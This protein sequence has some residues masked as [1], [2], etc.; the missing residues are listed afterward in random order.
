MDKNSFSSE[1]NN[2]NYNNPI[3]LHLYMYTCHKLLNKFIRKR[4]NEQEQASREKEAA[5]NSTYL[6]PN[7]PKKK[8]TMSILEKLN[9][10]VHAQSQNLL[11]SEKMV[12][13]ARA[14]T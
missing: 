13:E 2:H 5:Q 11:Q 9:I 3:L 1:E 12:Y 4:F 8:V 6:L 14:D 10:I 7:S